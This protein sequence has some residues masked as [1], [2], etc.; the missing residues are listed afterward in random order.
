MTPTELL[1]AAEW[2]KAKADELAESR[3]DE[4]ARRLLAM[5]EH[6]LATV[7]AD[8]GE[9]VTAEWLRSECGFYGDGAVTHLWITHSFRLYFFDKITRPSVMWTGGDRHLHT[10]G[11]VRDLLRALKGKGE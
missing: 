5:A 10:R 8:D 4:D 9:P 1:A 2:A 11:R 7:A 6:I 3:Y